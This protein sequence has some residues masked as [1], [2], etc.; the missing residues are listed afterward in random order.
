MAHSWSKN[1][2]KPLNLASIV[3][4]PN[5]MPKETHKWF[6]KF[7]GNNVVTLEDHLYAIG[8]AL[9]NEGV[10]HE[11]VVMRLLAMSLD[12]DDQG[13]FRGL[14]DN[15]LASYDDFAKSLTSRWSTK[16]DNKMLLLA[17]F[18]QI[19]K[20]ENETMKEFDTRF[21]KL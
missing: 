14:P 1:I 4:Y 9:L 15:H 18:N 12:E 10:E 17:Q 7:T 5:T 8:V 20:K 2:F 19:K 16:K 6:P 13:W 21:D 11:D 3:G